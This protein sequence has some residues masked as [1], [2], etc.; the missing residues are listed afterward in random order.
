MNKEL[1]KKIETEL[2]AL[3]KN[4]LSVHNKETA[5]AI[6][7]H[8]RDGVKSIAKKF[9]K[10]L[11][12]P[13]NAKRPVVKTKVATKR[14]TAVKKSAKAKPTTRKKMTVKKKG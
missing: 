7:K 14:K 5:A 3:I 13:E 11:P 9:V 8:I 12:V 6:S 2:S 4:S 1:R 10:H